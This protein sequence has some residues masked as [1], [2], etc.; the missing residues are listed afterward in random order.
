MSHLRTVTLEILRPGPAHNQLLSPLT[1]YL[2]ICDNRG[3]V[4]L[5]VP[6]EHREIM[7]QR[8]ALSYA[9]PASQREAQL[10]QTA[11]AMGAIL[12]KISP[13]GAAL[14]QVQYGQNALI[15]LR[16]VLSASELAL[17][18]FELAQAPQG[19]PGEDKPLLV[20][21][22]APITLTRE[23]RMATVQ[24]GCWSRPMRVLVA[25]AAPPGVP[26][27]PVREHLLALRRALAPWVSTRGEGESSLLDII[28]LLPRASV[29]AIR[30][31][32]AEG[33][34]T[35]VHILAHGTRYM[36][37][38]EPRYG[39]ALYD[40]TGTK[41]EVVSASRLAPALRTHRKDGKGFASPNVLTLASC[42]SSSVGSV[43]FPGASLAHDLHEA[44]LP[45]V[46][47]SQFPLSVRG[48]VLM[49][50]V[51]YA[52]FAWGE[53]PRIALHLLRQRL[54]AE[55]METH[56][57]ASLVAYAAVP[58]DFDQQIAE[59]RRQQ[60]HRAIN[61]SFGQVDDFFEHRRWE[62]DGA[63]WSEADHERLH[64]IL[65]QLDQHLQTL[66][67]MSP[68]GDT[69]PERKQRAEIRGLM[70]TAE[71]RRAHRLQR[72]AA[73]MGAQEATPETDWRAALRK[74]RGYYDE[75]MRLQLHNHW[76]VTQYLSL[77]K[78]LGEDL[79]AGIWTVA[80][81]TAEQSISHASRSEQAW[82]HADLAELFLLAVGAPNL[83]VSDRAAR[84]QAVEHAR[85]L[86]SL[87]GGAS[88]EVA[89]TRRQFERYAQ[90]WRP[91]KEVTAAA[92]A[93]LKVL[94]QER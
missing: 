41:L 78:V 44:G 25:V 16:L 91:G 27:V 52:A 47:G 23:V 19:F 39:L 73:A 3:A 76:M 71:K 15:H 32:C 89:S 14:A 43:L 2:A 38:G 90:W 64:G 6:F 75:A 1:D 58:P 4:T 50:E 69:P 88:F 17:L 42:D 61:V 80:R 45:W 7:R 70:G 86:L 62:Q 84:Q 5:S 92:E 28:T 65:A 20:Q 74:A 24:G 35:H 10:S 67:R 83:E 68:E 81:V 36:E 54:R 94:R 53:D 87:S 93:V 33:D 72:S 49:T 79:D 21:S 63:G 77:C 46:I 31:A 29:S 12:G 85:R 8:E 48:S 60:A 34:Y 9:V 66:S 56:D 18:P 57:W 26:P 59:A 13:L 51:L 37:A 40:S 22:I 82:A 11:D 30:E 55:C